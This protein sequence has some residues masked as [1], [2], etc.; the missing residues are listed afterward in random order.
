MFHDVLISGWNGISLGGLS[1]LRHFVAV[2]DARMPLGVF[3]FY[4]RCLVNSATVRG[5]SSETRIAW[6][7]VSRVRRSLA[8]MQNAAIF[9]HEGGEGLR[10]VSCT[11][12]GHDGAKVFLMCMPR[13]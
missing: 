2:P 13:L 4:L 3:D 7:A 6:F 5:V 8:A 1:D 10:F 12:Q 9:A 11:F